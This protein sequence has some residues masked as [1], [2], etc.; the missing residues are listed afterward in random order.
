MPSIKE[1]YDYKPEMLGEIMSGLTEPD[2]RAAVERI[3]GA[4]TCAGLPVRV[5][6]ITPKSG[7]TYYRVVCYVRKG[8]EAVLINTRNDLGKKGVFN[9]LN[10]QLRISD[11]SVFG[12]LDS[13]PEN[14]RDTIINAA[15][16]VCC[17]PKCEGKKYVFTY[18]GREYTKCQYLCA[19][20]RFWVRSADDARGIV[21]LVENE[22]KGKKKG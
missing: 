13:L 1:A 6:Q 19:N 20:F 8:T 10:I 5:R 15:D 2:E 22:I 17:T 12:R 4:F 14:V 11:R 16:C 21:G 7:E 3:I 18:G 9:G